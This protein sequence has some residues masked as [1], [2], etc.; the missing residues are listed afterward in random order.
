MSRAAII[1]LV[2][3]PAAFLGIIVGFIWY[4]T[5]NRVKIVNNAD[6]PLRNIVLEV[7]TLDGGGGSNNVVLRRE[8]SQIEPGESTYY[9]F[10]E[11]DVVAR[12]QFGL[13]G[14]VFDFEEMWDLWSGEGR[15][16]SIDS[17][18]SVT[19]DWAFRD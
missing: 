16:L 18:G 14:Q 13:N 11:N 3:V 7:Q 1:K 17:Q 8:I 2:V 6:V 4:W 5:A 19:S 9:M 10:H 12:L 15:E